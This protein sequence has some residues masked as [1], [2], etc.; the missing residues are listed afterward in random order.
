MAHRITEDPRMPH[1]THL[2]CLAKSVTYAASRHDP[3]TQE[4]LLSVCFLSQTF[5]QLLKHS[6][7]LRLDAVIWKSSV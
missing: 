7:Y 5:W 1:T 3:V 6:L 4:G 2:R